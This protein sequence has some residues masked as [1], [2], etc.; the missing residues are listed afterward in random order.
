VELLGL[1][2][3]LGLSP[4]FFEVDTCAGEFEARTPYYYS[5]YELAL[6]SPREAGRGEGEGSFPWTPD[7]QARLARVPAGF[8]RENTRLKIEEYAKETSAA[9]ITLEVAEK[10][11]ERSRQ[12]MA[13]MVAAYTQGKKQ[14]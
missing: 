8:M 6:P 5:A 13:E 2:R 7:A 1:R 4:Q 11:I 12:M 10:G 3:R 9:A 14:N